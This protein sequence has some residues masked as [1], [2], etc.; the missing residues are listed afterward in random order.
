MVE[1]YVVLLQGIYARLLPEELALVY[2]RKAWKGFFSKEFRHLFLFLPRSNGC[3][4]SAMSD[5]SR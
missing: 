3:G 2:G 1:H 4:E 5:G